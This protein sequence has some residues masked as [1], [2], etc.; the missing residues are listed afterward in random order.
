MTAVFLNT[1]KRFQRQSF[2]DEISETAF[3]NTENMQHLP[4]PTAD[5]STPAYATGKITVPYDRQ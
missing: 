3:R 1:W 2:W 4:F 5:I